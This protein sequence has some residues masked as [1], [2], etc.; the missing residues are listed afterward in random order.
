MMH[1]GVCSWVGIKTPTPFT[2]PILRGNSYSTDNQQD[3]CDIVRVDH[4]VDQNCAL[5]SVQPSEILGIAL[6]TALGWCLH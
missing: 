1:E 2:F 3:L 6:I 4:W 5:T